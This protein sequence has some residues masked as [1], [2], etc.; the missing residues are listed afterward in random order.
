MVAINNRLYPLRP[1]NN[2]KVTAG[3]MVVTAGTYL[4][5]RL[6]SALLALPI[7]R[8]DNRLPIKDWQALES[9]MRMLCRLN[10]ISSKPQHYR[11]KMRQVCRFFNMPRAPGVNTRDTLLSATGPMR[12]IPARHYRPQQQPAPLPGI[13][14]MHMGG[15]V[16]GDLDTCDPFCSLLAAQ[17]PAYVVSLDYRLAPEN[18]YPAAFMDAFA[19]Y[20]WLLE[21]AETLGLDTT[22][23]AIAGDSA[24]GCMAL[25]TCLEMR[26]RNRIQPKLQLAVYPTT[27]LAIADVHYTTGGLLD[28]ALMDWFGD[29]FLNGP[30]EAL[31]SLASPLRASHL[32]GLAPA[33]IATAGCD[34]LSTQARCYAKRLQRA[35]ISA[36][37]LHY[38]SL[39]HGFLAFG[40]ISPVAR[41]ACIQLVDTVRAALL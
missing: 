16:A 11:R 34:P 10:T 19:G 28:R 40:G 41:R 3:R 13:L 23:L 24:G 31:Q 22:K 33:I 32:Q 5:Q 18:R 20:E 27:D 21:Q 39:A 35:G 14:F 7:P 36:K 29:K 30:Q 4:L 2:A 1:S 38:P 26:R 37:H 6:L 12:R 17:V 25:A 15:W 8:G 9:R